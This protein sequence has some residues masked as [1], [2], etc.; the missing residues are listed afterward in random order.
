MISSITFL[1]SLSSGVNSNEDIL[2]D[3]TYNESLGLF[4]CGK[5]IELNQKEVK[6][7]CPNEMMCKE[8]MNKNKNR[9]N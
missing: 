1:T 6:R 9:Y 4:F 7:C 5:K 8:C 3:E 2:K